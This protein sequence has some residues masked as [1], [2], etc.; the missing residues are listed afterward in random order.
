MVSGMKEGEESAIPLQKYKTYLVLAIMR[1]LESPAC[2][3]VL[4]YVHMCES[5]ILD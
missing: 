5:L 1:E 2:Y 3:G 4:Y